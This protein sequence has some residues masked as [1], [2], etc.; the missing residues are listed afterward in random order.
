MTNP[1]D[2]AVMEKPKEDLVSKI[3]NH[4]EEK[5]IIASLKSFY[6][7]NKEIIIRELEKSI[8]SYKTLEVNSSSVESKK[9]FA[10]QKV[11]YKRARVLYKGGAIS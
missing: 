8:K 5:K 11:L 6:K 7:D 9:Y 3:R 2:S 4:S 10:E 1:N